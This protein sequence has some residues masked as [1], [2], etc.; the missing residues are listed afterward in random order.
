[1][2]EV[3]FI[4]PTL[5]EEK[6]IESCLKSI[7]SQKTSL[8]FEIILSD[9]KSTDKTVEVAEK[10]VDKVIVPKRKGIATGRNMGAKAAK[11][12]SLLFVDAD[13]SIPPNYANVVHHVLLNE[14]IA[15]VCC[16]FKFDSNDLFPKTV[17]KVTNN[18]LLIKGF[19]SNSPFLGFDGS[20]RA[21]TFKKVGGFPDKLLEDRA[22]GLKLEKVGKVV[23]LPEPVVITSSRRLEQQGPLGSINYYADL[24]LF[25]DYNIPKTFKELFKYNKYK[26]IR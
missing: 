11:G 8:D 10:Y 12:K 4:I 23:Y 14:E 15:G 26:Q 22:F 5:N 21:S 2:T 1:M 13:T 18:Y 17:E 7:R 24:Q 3:S 25:T 19:Q 6:Y 16:A 9:S 20:C